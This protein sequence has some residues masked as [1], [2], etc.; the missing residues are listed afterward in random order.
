M[1]KSKHYVVVGRR[2]QFGFF[3]G[4]PL[5]AFPSAAIGA[6]AIATAM[7]LVFFMS[8]AGTLAAVMMHAHVARA[9]VGQLFDYVPTVLI[10]HC[11]HCPLKPHMLAF[12][13][14]LSH[15]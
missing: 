9:A 6:M 8:T 2:Q 13:V 1:G 7:K 3:V 4:Y 15:F 11:S 14:Y 12:L 5:V 10:A